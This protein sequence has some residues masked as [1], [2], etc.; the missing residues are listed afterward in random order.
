MNERR[1]NGSTDKLRS[2]ERLER[3]QLDRVVA[4]SLAGI[5]VKEV[6]D[7]GT[8]T[9]L[10]AEAFFKKGLSVKAVDCNPEFLRLAEE[11]VPGAAF[12]EAPAE[13]LPFA[14]Q[15]CD[16]VFMGHLL[17]ET[18]DAEASVRE[19]FRVSRC[20]LAVLEWPYLEQQVGPPLEHRIRVEEVKRLG[21]NAGFK[22]CDVIQLN[23]MQLVIFDR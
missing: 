19:A 7:V 1:F 15:S 10:F 14:D 5:K 12:F 8:G 16:L 11:I 17:H 4:Y 13:R 23:L 6:V 22:F 9:G 3:L 20:R 2:P 21:L 18:D